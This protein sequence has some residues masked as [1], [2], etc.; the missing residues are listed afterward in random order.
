M[1][2]IRMRGIG[3]FP[4]LLKLPKKATVQHKFSS[5]CANFVSVLTA[6]LVRSHLTALSLILQHTSNNVWGAITASNHAKERGLVRC[7][8]LFC[9]STFLSRNGGIGR[10]KV[11]PMQDGLVECT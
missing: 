6:H 1:I 5:T 4:N 9:I 3:T 8:E 2:Q 11:F 10:R 7:F